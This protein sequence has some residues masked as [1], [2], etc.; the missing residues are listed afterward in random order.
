MGLTLPALRF[1]AEAFRLGKDKILGRQ[2]AGDA[3]L[4]ALLSLPELEELWGHGP[5]P[6]TAAAFAATVAGLRKGLRTG[7][8]PAGDAARLSA[9]GGVHYPDPMLAEP[10]RTRLAA[11]A[12]AWSITGITHTIASGGAMAGLAA[13]PLAPLME[14]DGLVLTSDAVKASVLELLDAQD[15]YLAWRFPGA[16][17]APRPQM[18]VIPLGVHTADFAVTEPAREEAR[19]ALGLGRG[20][21]AFLFVGRLS[22][23][24]KAHPWP[25]YAALEEAARR[26]GRRIALI[27]CGW[28]AN[29]GI[30]QAF[31]AGAAT[32]A[33]SV[34]HLWLDGRE[35]AQR[36]R[37]WAAGDVFVSL[38]D[39]IQETFGLTPLEAMAAGMPV[40]ATDWNGYRQ[41][42]RHGETGFMVPTFAPDASIGDAYA[43]DH[44]D[45][46]INYDIYLARTA[47]HVS[48][49]LGA[50]F[51]AAERLAADAGLRKAMGAAGQRMARERFEWSILVRDYLALWDDLA[52]IRAAARDDPRFA[53]RRA[54]ERLNPFALFGNY[55][56]RPVTGATGL[57]RRAGGGDPAVL[58]ADPLHSIFV[59]DL[60]GIE[61]VAALLA[62]V[63]GDVPQPLAAIAA[64]AGLSTEQGM[65][66]ATVLLK[67]GVFEAA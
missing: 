10:A 45:G 39:N 24:A 11:G 35:A 50:L 44:A 37:A 4:R 49:D 5:S 51:D 32:H 9:L 53:P 64:A 59:A 42:V 52:R 3:F 60:G 16:A 67:L 12:A 38:S 23:H 30:E 14:W 66:L 1:E 31:K 29:G 57:R 36:A 17:P 8:V 56:S 20:D 62:K 18:P 2:S 6:A 61:A 7:W 13:Y 58:L 21:V 41:T 22:F 65:A 25:M 19:R 15:D 48:I 33:P 63:P 27:Q 46:V 40:L 43:D 54:A 34:R 47:R 28:F 26:T 55:P